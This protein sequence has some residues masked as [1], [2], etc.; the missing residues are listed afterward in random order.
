MNAT[1]S[2]IRTLEESV[3]RHQYLYYVKNSPEISDKEFDKLFKELQ[4]LE[5]K[6]P[7]LASNN[8]PTKTI[9]SDLDNQF[10]KYKHKIP[11]L[12]LENTY[13]IEELISWIQKTDPNSVYSVEWKIDGASIVLY[14]ENGELV[15]GVS[16]GTGGVGDDVTENIRTIKNIPLKL[17]KP[18]SIFVRGEVYMT[19]TDFISVNEENDGRFANPRNLAAGSIKYKNSSQTAKRP[20]K[21]FAYDAYFPEGYGKIKTHSELLELLSEFSFPVSS[22]TKFTTGKNIPKI[23]ED[24]KKKKEKLDYPVDGLVVKLDNLQD[25]NTLGETSHS[26]R[27]ARA[28]KFD[29][30]LKETIIEDIDFAIGRTGKITPRAKV[31]PVSLAGTTVTYATLHNQDFIN[32]LGV[33]IGAKVLIAKRGEIIPAVEEVIEIGEKGIFQL[34]KNCPSC[35]TKL[36]KIDESVDLFCTNKHCPERE[37][38]SLIFFCQKKQMDIEGLGDKQ[39]ENFYHQKIIK[40]IPDLYELHKKKSDL[41]QMEGLG[42]KSVEIILSGIEKSKTKDFQI[43][44]PSLGLSEIG[45]KVTEIL[46]ENGFDSIEKIENV[47]KNPDGKERLLN[48]HGLGPRTVDSIINHFQDKEILELIQKLKDFGLQ[49]ASSGLKKSDT[50]VFAGQSWCVTGSFE[51]F[52]PREKALNLI[53]Y[54]GGKKVSSVSSKT[55]HLLAGDG[56]GS[57]LDKAKELGVKIIDEK[58]FLGILKENNLSLKI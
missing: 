23:I 37:M 52:H 19:F 18:L 40:N 34:P 17:K 36:K 27:W 38:N 4:G 48:I 58:E 22:D 20:L 41:I 49:F 2:K 14:Y 33:G 11:V 16:R 1:E 45:H 10:K 50:L 8:S 26:P 46:I 32:E 29:A 35:G 3:R 24:F 28:F 55:T 54:Y 12:S 56:A 5:D 6:Y 13:N 21:I 43:V 44:L 57:K 39:I 25:R 42:E 53:A 51:N 31:N 7:D 9:G 47:V 30:E 15:N